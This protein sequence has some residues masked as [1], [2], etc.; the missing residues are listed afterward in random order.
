V[1]LC[2]AVY[3]VIKKERKKKKKKNLST[4]VPEFLVTP[5]VTMDVSSCFLW[6]N[7]RRSDACAAR[8]AACR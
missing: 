4:R 8:L 6:A 5:I 7:G 2:A 1:C 3:G